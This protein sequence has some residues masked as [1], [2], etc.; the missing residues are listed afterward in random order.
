MTCD[1]ATFMPWSAAYF[2]AMAARSGSMPGVGAYLVFPAMRA[3]THASLICA[4]VSKSG[5]PAAKPHTSSPAAAMA[6]AFASTASVGDGEMLRAQVEREAGAWLM[7]GR[8]SWSAY[9]A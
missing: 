4:G 6:L 1:G 8:K 7:D 2:S 3:A 5:S 9:G